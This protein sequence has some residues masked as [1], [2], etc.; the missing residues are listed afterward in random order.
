MLRVASAVPVCI[1]DLNEPGSNRS[2]HMG[3][4]CVVI[5]VA[6]PIGR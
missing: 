1:G 4:N 5:H 2:I 3:D 6:E